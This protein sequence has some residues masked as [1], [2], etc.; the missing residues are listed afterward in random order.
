[1]RALILHPQP[2]PPA[3]SGT[4]VAPTR[5]A[6][7]DWAQASYR[8]E[9]L[10]QPILQRQGWQVVDPLSARRQL[11]RAVQDCLQPRDLAGTARA[12]QPAIAA[13]LRTS[14]DLSQPPADATPRVAQL[15]QLA[16]HYRQGLRDQQRLAPADLLWQAA[17]A[18]QPDDRHAY[19][20][21]GYFHPRWDQLAAIDAI[22]GPG[23]QWLLPAGDSHW[24][25]SNQQAVAWLQERGWQVQDAEPEPSTAIALGSQLQQCFLSQTQVAA[26]Q[27]DRLR[28]TRHDN[29]EAEVRAVLAQVK[30]QLAAGVAARDLALV[31]TNERTYGPLLLDIAWEYQVPVRVLYEIPLRETRLGAWLALLLQ[32]IASD[33]PYEATARALGHPLVQALSAEVWAQARQQR[34]QG[35]DAWQALGLELAAYAWPD[36]TAPRATWLERWHRLREASN[37]RQRV[38]RWPR[39]AIA[40]QRLQ[41]ALATLASDRASA[42]APLSRAAFCEELSELL[43]L[44]NA[45]LHPGRGG[46]ELHNPLTLFGARYAQVFVLGAVEGWL[47]ATLSNDP[48]LDFHARQQLAASGFPLETA[49]A[50]ARRAALSIYFLLG[51]PTERLHLSYPERQERETLLPSAYLAQLGLEPTAAAKQPL[52]SWQEV[53]RSQLQVSAATLDAVGD[54]ARHAWQVEQRR[55]SAAP[56]DEYDGL[57]GQPLDPAARWFSASQ[58]LTFGQCPF[59]WFAGRVLHL[60]APEEAAAD[61]ETSQRGQ[62]YHRCL[63][64][65]LEDGQT[66]LEVAQL[67]LARLAEAFAAAE[68]D[69]AL[70]DFP[71]WSVRRDEHLATLQLNLSAPDFLQ[72]DAQIVARELRFE[73]SDW[74]GLRVRG[75]IDRIDRG[76]NGLRVLDYKTSSRAPA[77]AKDASG[78]AKLD[79]QLSIYLA[80][81][82]DRFPDE[83]I[84]AAD[85]YSLTKQEN[86]NVE[87]SATGDL[88]DLSAQIQTQLASGAYPVDPDRSGAACRYCNFDLVCR[89][90]PRLARKA[91]R[92]AAAEQAPEFGTS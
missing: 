29:L 38:S 4:L 32:A 62:L 26:P 27:R 73:L 63:E 40:D 66:A 31:A 69:L 78:A 15:V 17:A 5:Q 21:Y 86:L 14:P 39:E 58:L 75:S 56:P 7:R 90:G 28:A 11:R 51:V 70:P 12:L 23:S 84:A 49:A 3:A 30:V 91:A 19:C 61:L 92:S 68:Q 25:A 74:H 8:L 87:L 71:A 10:L 16:H 18:A 77:G 50:V 83:A 6:A 67:S 48:W 9:Q 2:N 54:R 59:K 34:P 85:Y 44:L 55:E 1:M 24:F 33:F 89:R 35:R 64:R 82:R 65:A 76:P 45:P 47:P 13:L 22:A 53:R 81:V 88:A 20:F 37:L 79:V 60:Q 43:D 80:A 42:A 41:A 72:P 36:E 52:A 57:S 46:V